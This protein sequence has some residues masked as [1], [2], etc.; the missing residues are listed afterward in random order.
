MSPIDFSGDEIIVGGVPGHQLISGL[1]T[2]GLSD[3]AIGSVL[4]QLIGPAQTLLP[5]AAI[6]S[7]PF[8]FQIQ[9][10]QTAPDC[11]PTYQRAF[12]HPDFFDGLTVVQAGTTPEELGF[13]ARFHAIEAEFDA[14]ALDLYKSGNCIAELRRELYGLARELEVKITQIDELLQ[15]KGKEKEGKDSKEKDTKEGKEKD[16]KEGKDKEKEGK[17]HKDKDKEREKIQAIEKIQALEQVPVLGNLPGPDPATGGQTPEVATGGQPASAQPSS[18]G[19]FIT[20]SERPPVGQQPLDDSGESD[21][22]EGP[23]EPPAESPAEPPAGQAPA[24]PARTPRKRTSRKPRA[25][26]SGDAKEGGSLR[27]PRPGPRRGRRGV[28]PGSAVGRSGASRDGVTD[29]RPAA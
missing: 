19:T 16:T 7:P 21:V 12:V 15:A 23:A 1:R 4:A 5:A 26:K 17:D 8:T 18:G 6:T 24:Q 25:R 28:H 27:A 9:I 14:V 20:P 11:I 2:A 22:P 29:R 3:E 13:N 10:A